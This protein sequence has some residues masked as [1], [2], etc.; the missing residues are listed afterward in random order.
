MFIIIYHD[1]DVYYYIPWQWCLLLWYHD[2]DVYY[3][4]TM[5][6]MFIIIIYYDND[7]Y[8]SPVKFSCSSSNFI[9]NASLDIKSVWTAYKYWCDL[10]NC[11]SE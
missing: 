5:T 2:N 7:V 4:D 8:Y 10:N 6:T 3:Y 11:M 9:T 1:N